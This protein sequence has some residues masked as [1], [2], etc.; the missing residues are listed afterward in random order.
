MFLLIVPTLRIVL[1]RAVPRGPPMCC[2]RVPCCAPT[3]A[4]LDDPVLM[5]EAARALAGGAVVNRHRAL[6]AF[7]GFD[8]W[9]PVMHAGQLLHSNAWPY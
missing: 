6:A 3:A 8:R 1:Y 9:T 5:V 7:A 2:T 4:R